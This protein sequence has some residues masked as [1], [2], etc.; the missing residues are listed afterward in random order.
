MIKAIGFTG[1]ELQTGNEPAARQAGEKCA[2]K[3]ARRVG[4]VAER[5][6]SFV[7]ATRLGHLDQA[8]P[9]TPWHILEMTG[10]HRIGKV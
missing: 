10:K 6:R 2:R 8:R 1:L 7:Q 9:E 3:S 5:V 4:R